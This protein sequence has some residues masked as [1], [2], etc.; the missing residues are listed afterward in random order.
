M[1]PIAWYIR[2]LRSMSTGEVAWR[3]RSLVRDR[4]D[5]YR[6]GLGM[7]PSAQAAGL[8][9]N[10]ADW[11]MGFRVSDVKPG[12]WLQDKVLEDEHRWQADL[13][14][15][16]EKILQHH[17]SFFDLEDCFLGDPI[18]WNRDHSAHR[19]CPTTHAMA[20]DY[21]DFS[22]VGDCKL[23]WEPNRHHHLVVLARAYRATGEVRFA[24]AVT[25]QLASWIEQNPFG[26]GMNWRSPLELAVRLINWVWALD[27]IRESGLL[28]SFIWR[29]DHGR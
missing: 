28:Q 10:D 5:R 24:K 19:Q 18:D 12:E 2:R 23:V 21:R 6:F 8:G 4:F 7:Y 14:V 20:I 15:R 25:E 22:Q 13:V 9:G 26:T 16:A 27:L 3:I 1:Q 11:P 17:L 29:M